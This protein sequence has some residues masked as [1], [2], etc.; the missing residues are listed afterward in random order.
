MIGRFTHVRWSR[1]LTRLALI[2]VGF[3]AAGASLSDAGVQAEEPA[4]AICLSGPARTP[5]SLP[6]ARVLRVDARGWVEV[7]RTDDDQLAAV[8]VVT[9]FDGLDGGELARDLSR[10][11]FGDV[12]RYYRELAEAGMDD[13]ATRTGLANALFLDGD[14]GGAVRAYTW[15]WSDYPGDPDLRNGLGN[16]LASVELVSQAYEEFVILAAS[17]AYRAIAL[18]N[19]GN[20]YQQA[21]RLDRAVE[22]YTRAAAADPG[23]VA[24]HYNSGV[25]WMALGRMESAADAFRQVTRLAPSMAQGYLNEGLALLRSG[26]SVRAAVALHRARDLDPNSDSITLALALASQDVGLDEQAVVLFQQAL[27]ANPTDERIHH[28]LANSL[29]RTGRNAEAAAT[30]KRAFALAPRDADDH[31]QLGLKLFLCDQP[32]SASEQFMQAMSKG[33][34]D[35][36]VFFALGQAMLQNGQTDAAVESLTV[37]SRMK[38]EAAE[39]H[40]SLGLA[41]SVADRLEDAVDEVKTAAALDPNDRNIHG[42]LTG[43]Q[44]RAGDFAGCAQV[45]RALVRRHPEL[46]A[47]RFDVALCLALDGKLDLAAEAL[48][49]ALDHDLDG[50]MVHPL[51]RRV[52]TLAE[53]RA[54]APGPYLLLALIHERRGNWSEAVEA[55]ERFILV[56]PEQTWVQRALTRIH[57]LALEPSKGP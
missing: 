16:V 18:N 51:W 22:E 52:E 26:Q 12:A 37:A 25:A 46:I 35:A 20:A 47:P 6:K 30:L 44:L 8:T 15:A 50:T 38:P 31:F 36:E 19:L 29:V 57:S 4:D 39:I 3:A 43:L 13:L 45:G 32:R 28:L 11:E 33:R 53:V 5:R 40:F 24:A 23:L 48:E 41:L 10:G 2:V 54:D 17:P 9:G 21:N 55:Y 7:T 56:K 49:D 34:R 42:M 14:L 1:R 27:L